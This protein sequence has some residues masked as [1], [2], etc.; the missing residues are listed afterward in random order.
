MK[1]NIIIHC[2]KLYDVR[3]YFVEAHKIVHMVKRHD[4]HVLQPNR[5]Y[6]RKRKKE[7]KGGAGLAKY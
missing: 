1:N 4:F 6:E 7:R 5:C 3:A 2:K